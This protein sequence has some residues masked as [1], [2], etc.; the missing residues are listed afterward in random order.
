MQTNDKEVT[1]LTVSD[2][3]ANIMECFYIIA[4]QSQ[5]NINN[6]ALMLTYK[7]FTFE[8]L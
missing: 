1:K 4:I 3:N 8:K 6:L 5:H 7:Q 2:L